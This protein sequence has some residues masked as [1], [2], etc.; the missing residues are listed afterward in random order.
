MIVSQAP[1]PLPTNLQTV[2]E[3][4]QWERKHARII[5]VYFVDLTKITLHKS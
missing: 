2:D 5:D 4:E 1:L 3:F